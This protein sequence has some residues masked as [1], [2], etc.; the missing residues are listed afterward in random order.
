M[1]CE[2]NLNVIEITHKNLA[3]LE[4]SA[5]TKMCMTVIQKI[6]FTDFFEML[7]SIAV[8]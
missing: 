2:I 4:F 8:L 3:K 5:Q 6:K 7:C 1:L